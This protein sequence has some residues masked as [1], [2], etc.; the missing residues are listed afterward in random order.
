MTGKAFEK[1]ID[2]MEKLRGPEGCP[3]DREQTHD[4]LRPY[5]LEETYEVLETLDT[6][7]YEGLKEELG[8]FILQSVFH[9]QIAR[10][11]KE[12]DMLDVLNTINE[13]LIRRHPHVFGEVEIKTADEQKVHWER[14]KKKEGKK[15]VLDGVPKT[16]PSLLR[17]ARIQ[18]KAATVGFDW[19]DTAPVWGKIDEETDELRRAIDDSDRDAILEEFGDLLFAMVN[20]SRFLRVNPEDAL[21]LAVE[22]FIDRF[23]K[24]EDRYRND[25]K[26]LKDA[27]LEEMD[28]V[29]NEIKKK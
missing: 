15:S 13:K 24:L 1:L 11:N 17:A 9:A 10:E 18:Q 16:A 14:L 5:L 28:Q 25:K 23:H 4:S 29:W 2:I 20:L 26:S 22:K 8:D 21:R 7:D 12:F 19:P 6:K 3:W 27:T